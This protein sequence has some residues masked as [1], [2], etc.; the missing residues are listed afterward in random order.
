MLN[1]TLFTY[2]FMLLLKY[3]KTLHR[4]FILDSVAE[5]SRAG[6]MQHFSIP[7]SKRQCL[8]LQCDPLRYV[9]CLN[10]DVVCGDKFDKKLPMRSMAFEIGVRINNLCFKYSQDIIHCMFECVT[11]I[12]WYV[13]H[14][15]VRDLT[16]VEG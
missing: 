2:I 15:F 8:F 1:E 9:C 11:E 4:I 12:E 14:K 13:F 3:K 16:N 7:I 6:Q 5:F 10:I